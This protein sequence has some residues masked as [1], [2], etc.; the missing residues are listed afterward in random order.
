MLYSWKCRYCSNTRQYDKPYKEGGDYYVCN[1]CHEKIVR[2]TM[3][4][5][6]I[7]REVATIIGSPTIQRVQEQLS[8]N[9]P[10]VAY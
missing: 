8:G 4:A 6:M 9:A 7:V 2:R 3:V 5:G 1:S 10:A